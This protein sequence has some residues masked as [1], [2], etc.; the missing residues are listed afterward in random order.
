ML[1]FF[2]ASSMFKKP[3]RLLSRYAYG[4]SNEYLTPTCAAKL[5]TTSKADKL[6]FKIIKAQ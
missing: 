1:L 6:H 3:S 5:I 2:D 4:L